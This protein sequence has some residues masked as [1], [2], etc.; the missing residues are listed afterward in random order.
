MV[1]KKNEG[2]PRGGDSE[3]KVRNLSRGSAVN[4]VQLKRGERN[5]FRAEEKS[6]LET[7]KDKVIE[8]TLDAEKKEGLL[9]GE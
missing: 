9:L 6:Q 5:S 8:G 4:E 1:Q 2:G 7:G 3:E